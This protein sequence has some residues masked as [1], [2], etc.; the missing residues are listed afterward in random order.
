MEKNN[1]EAH[2]IRAVLNWRS[3]CDKRGLS[4]QRRGQYNY[5]MLSFI[6]D[7]LMPWH[8]QHDY[9]YLEVN[10]YAQINPSVHVIMDVAVKSLHNF[11]S[12]E[13]QFNRQIL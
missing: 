12:Q 8:E 2:Y 3:S 11:I 13:C 5:Q 4:K 7:D 9:S 1:F 10:R 6:L